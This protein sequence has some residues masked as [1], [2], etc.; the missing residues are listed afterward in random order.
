[1]FIPDP[2]PLQRILVFL[3]LTTVSKL[4]K[5]LSEMFIP[6]PDPDFFLSRILNPSVKKHRIL[7]PDPQHWEGV[8]GDTWGKG[9]VSDWC[10]IN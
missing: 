8:R 7:D 1:M 5:K 9:M 3:T 10:R 6:D 4:S 2:D